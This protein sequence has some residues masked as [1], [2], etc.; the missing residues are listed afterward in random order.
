MAFLQFYLHDVAVKTVL[1]YR[2]NFAIV[3]GFNG[4]VFAVSFYTVNIDGHG[5]HGD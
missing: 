3:Y 1:F 4:F 2:V 5:V